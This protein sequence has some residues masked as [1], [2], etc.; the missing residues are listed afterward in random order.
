[1][2]KKAS[3]KSIDRV[4]KADWIIMRLLCKIANRTSYPWQGDYDVVK[5]MIYIG[6]KYGHKVVA[7]AADLLREEYKK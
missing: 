1:M 4:T 7:Q 6:D 3:K 2:S 5:A